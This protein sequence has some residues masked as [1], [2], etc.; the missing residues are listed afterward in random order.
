MLRRSETLILDTDRHLTLAPISKEAKNETGKSVQKNNPFKNTRL[1]KRDKNTDSQDSLF[2]D[3]YYVDKKGKE[4]KKKKRVDI[5]GKEPVVFPRLAAGAITGD[6]S[7]G[8]QVNRQAVIRRRIQISADYSET[9]RS[10][11]E[12]SFNGSD[13]SQYDIDMQYH[14]SDPK[15][16]PKPEERQKIEERRQI[17]FIKQSKK[18]PDHL[19]IPAK[20]RSTVQLRPDLLPISVDIKREESSS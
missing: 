11:P 15:R 3:N 17:N 13:W 8:D 5:S 4:I 20:E 2:S 9:E 1:F 10:E 16:Y 18:K 6:L 12:Y 14:I 7:L 19:K